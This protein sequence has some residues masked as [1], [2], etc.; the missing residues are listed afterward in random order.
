MAD[1]AE[2]RRVALAAAAAMASSRGDIGL[3]ADHDLHWLT[4]ADE[5]YR[6]LSN[7][8]AKESTMTEDAAA[9]EA[10]EDVAADAEGAPA[11]DAAE[12]AE[13]EAGEDAAEGDAAP[14]AEPPAA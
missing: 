8:N 5:A 3:R 13:P 6:W 9:A 14:A 7:H 4:L 2:N 1:D 12:G 10:A 11:E